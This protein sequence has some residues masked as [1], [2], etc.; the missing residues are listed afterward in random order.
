MPLYYCPTLAA[1]LL[2]LPLYYSTTAPLV[3]AHDYKDPVYINS[4]TFSTSCLGAYA[5][6]RH[7]DFL[8]F[9]LNF[10]FRVALS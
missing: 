6:W 1:P 7:L 10:L 3:I 9:R 5:L 8:L 2:L 4:I